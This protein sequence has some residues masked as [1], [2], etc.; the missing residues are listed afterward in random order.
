[1]RSKIYRRPAGAGPAKTSITPIISP[2]NSTIISAIIASVTK[3]I[4]SAVVTPAPIIVTSISAVSA[5]AVIARDIVLGDENR[6]ND[7]HAEFRSGLYLCFLTLGE[8]SA[9]RTCN[10]ACHGA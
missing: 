5:I 9:E 4:V 2:I 1:L 6:A 8:D 10:A 7:L 3:A